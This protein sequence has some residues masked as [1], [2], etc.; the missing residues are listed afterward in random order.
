L[1]STGKAQLVPASG[2][3]AFRMEF[4]GGA[5]CQYERPKLSGVVGTPLSAAPASLQFTGQTFMLNRALSTPKTCAALGK[6]LA[7]NL[8]YGASY[9]EPWTN[10]HESLMIFK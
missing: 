6:P 4:S 2:K 5:K 8:Y 9:I 1:A 3:V 7:L 10:P